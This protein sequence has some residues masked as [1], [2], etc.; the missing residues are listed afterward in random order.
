MLLNTKEKFRKTFL[1][2]LI[3]SSFSIP[4]LAVAAADDTSP[5]VGTEG[6]GEFWKEP[7]Q[8]IDGDYKATLAPNSG[9]Q[10]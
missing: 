7:N 4:A 9:E 5:T 1:S 10:F 3:V 8:N 6:S 2:T